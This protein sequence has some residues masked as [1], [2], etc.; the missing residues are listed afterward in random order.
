MSRI[1]FVFLASLAASAPASAQLLRV[2]VSSAGAE[3]NGPSGPPSISADGRFVVFASTASNLVAGDTN[4]VSDVFLRDRDTD[5]DGVLDEAGAV[6]T[7]RLS[8]GPGATQATGAST[9]P[10]IS[11]DGRFVAFASTASN[12]VAGASALSQ[13]YRVDRT[14]GDV[15]RVSES[16]AGAAGDQ[17][18]TE[19]AI[20]ANGDAVAFTSTAINLVADA[21]SAQ[22]HVFI[23]EITADRTARLS[24][25][26]AS[27]SQ[28]GRPTISATG[29]RVAYVVVP[30]SATAP[31]SVHVSD[32]ATGGLRATFVT[33]IAAGTLSASGTRVIAGDTR[34]V[35]ESRAVSP[36][37][38]ALTPPVASGTASGS[39]SG[40]FVLGGGG[41]LGD[42]DLGVS[43]SLGF[44]SLGAAFTADDRWL[45]FAS[46]T[47]TLLSGNADANGVADVFVLNLPA[48]L[49]LDADTM[50]DRWETLFG[51]TSP[52]ADPDGDG[53]NNAAEESA[54][55]HPNGVQQRYFSEGATGAFFATRL[56]LANPDGANA[57]RVVLN[58]DSGQG[59]R[60]SYPLWLP[61]GG[62]ATVDIGAISGFEASDASTIVES[63]RL[64]VVDRAMEWGIDPVPTGHGYGSHAETAAP[65]ASTRWFLAEGST[66]LGF[67]LFYLLQNPQPTIAHT[68][69]RYLL[70]SG[71]VI[72][73]TYDMAPRSRTTIYVNVIPGI[74]EIDVSAD[75]SADQPIMAE[76]AMYRTTPGQHFGLGTVSAGVTAPSTRWF[77]AEGATGFFFDLYVLFANPSDSDAH[78]SVDYAREDG[79]VV[80]KTYLIRAHSRF[81]VYVD[82]I[83][84]LEHTSVATTVVSTNNVPIVVERAMYWPGGFFDYYEGHTSVGTTGT[85][86]RWVVARG[87]GEAATQT[88][89]L[90]ANTENRPGQVTLRIMTPAGFNGSLQRVVNLPANSRTTVEL[91]G[92][93][94]VY[95]ILAESSGP[96]PVE[97]VVESAVYRSYRG[98]LWAAGSN[99]VA[100]PLP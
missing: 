49:D 17:A 33:P 62:A 11:A 72:T 24:P 29:A 84:G 3:A 88:F 99:A 70:S 78:I 8:V 5:A 50:D 82:S 37:L 45:A 13:I 48:R 2:S 9:Q 34:Y 1:A 75:I 31:R 81:S 58:F 27:Q 38:T 76:R 73:R 56:W 74:E 26:D 44:T 6:A 87:D 39:A 97:L 63:D 18:S 43:S 68:T 20:S 85:A 79:I 64:V 80:N 90:F 25:L 7:T 51:V 95:G 23:R 100:T 35:V 41:T 86:Q 10:A 65:A 89:V 93:P 52:T 4:G 32:A 19:P 60:R 61:A 54:G 59:V 40:R 36:P 28:Y 67:E 92:M 22:P 46:D 30:A 21:G 53:A 98:A 15:I 14:T 47:S 96:S 66:V 57:A 69:V 16:A 71:T 42:F 12:L 91:T 77:L 94:A 55:T 83:P